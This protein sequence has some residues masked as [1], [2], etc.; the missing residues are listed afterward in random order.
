MRTHDEIVKAIMEDQSF[1]GFA[2][3]VW[4]E[5]LPWS[6]AK[7]FIK[8]EKHQEYAEK[9]DMEVY[10]EPTLENIVEPM[11]KYMKFAWEKVSDHRGLSA[12]R[13]IA[14]M[15]AWA[16]LMEDDALLREI[17]GAP[18]ENYGAPKLKAICEHMK[19]PMPDDEWAQNMA[20]GRPCHP[21][22]NNGCGQ[23]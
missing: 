13:S 16:W 19:W 9:W 8:E 23:P 1:L 18:Y 6:H 5:Y 7:E 22:C 3:E 17:E 20:S 4:L 14:K 21:D 10:H 15:D 2:S 12:G 11:A